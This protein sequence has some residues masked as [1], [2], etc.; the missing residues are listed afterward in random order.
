MSLQQDVVVLGGDSIAKTTQM[1]DCGSMAVQGR[2]RTG[3]TAGQ[4]GQEFR[5]FLYKAR[6]E[7]LHYMANEVPNIA[8][9]AKN[10]SRQLTTARTEADIDDLMQCIRYTLEHCDECPLLTIQE[11][12]SQHEL[13]P[14]EVYTDA[15][16]AGDPISMKSAS[17]V[18]TKIGAFLP[19]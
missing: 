13:A 2:K 17:S 11:A 10:V 6:V 12:H 8:H 3:R 7:K 9:A 19:D 14:T 4:V 18:F 15:D 5:V 16:W 1:E